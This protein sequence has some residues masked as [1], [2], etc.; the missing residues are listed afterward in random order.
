MMADQQNVE[1]A[2]SALEA[3][4]ADLRLKVRQAAAML[5]GTIDVIGV[6]ALCAADG[7]EIA[8]EARIEIAIASKESRRLLDAAGEAVVA[9]ALAFDRLASSMG[10]RP[11]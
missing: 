11:Q 1:A 6:M 10:P 3:A 9:A 7:E 4:T 5:A 2:L 8:A